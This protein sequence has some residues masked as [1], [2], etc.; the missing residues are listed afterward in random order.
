VPPGF[1]VT[2]AAYRRFVE[3]ND[4]DA[5]IVEATASAHPMIPPPWGGPSPRCGSFSRAAPH[6]TRSLP[7][8]TPDTPIM[9]GCSWPRQVDQRVELAGE[10]TATI[11]SDVPLVRKGL[12]RTPVNESPD[13]SSAVADDRS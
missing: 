6:R 8:S 2:T 9:M 11:A 7:L 10:R 12:K 4:L 5:V 1:H 13:S 3:A